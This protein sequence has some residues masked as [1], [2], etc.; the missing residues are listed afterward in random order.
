MKL[1]TIA[2]VSVAVAFSGCGGSDDGGGQSSA[3]G[4]NDQAQREFV[5]CAR[6]AERIAEQQNAEAASRHLGRCV[7]SY[8]NESQVEP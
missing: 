2:A 3:E 8:L 6:Q 1:V 5:T 7:E 4:A